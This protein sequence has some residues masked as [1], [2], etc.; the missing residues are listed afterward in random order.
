MLDILRLFLEKYARNTTTIVSK[1]K[2]LFSLYCVLQCK[3]F[4]SPSACDSCSNK[5]N[6]PIIL[7]NCSTSIIAKEKQ[8]NMLYLKLVKIKNR[9][10]ALTMAKSVRPV[11]PEINFP[12]SINSLKHIQNIYSAICLLEFNLCD[13]SSTI[14]LKYLYYVVICNNRQIRKNVQK[15]GM[16]K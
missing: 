4:F 12:L 11:L 10:N 7:K 1:E 15:Q 9:D 6:Q 5:N 16:V 3:N 2:N 8:V 13:L 14:F